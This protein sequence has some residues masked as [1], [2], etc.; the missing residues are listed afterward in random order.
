[1]VRNRKKTILMASPDPY[2]H[3][4]GHR[5]FQSHDTSIRNIASR[6]D[7]IP[8]LKN[9]KPDIIIFD[10]VLADTTI[11]QTIGEIKK[12]SPELFVVLISPDE[13][14]PEFPIDRI[15]PMPVEVIEVMKIAWHIF[16]EKDEISSEEKEQELCRLLESEIRSNIRL[17]DTHA[18]ILHQ[19]KLK[20]QLYS[21][22]TSRMQNPINI[23]ANFSTLMDQALKQSKASPALIKLS[24]EVH[25]AD[26][27]LAKLVEDLVEYTESE[28]KQPRLDVI[29]I[30]LSHLFES[31]LDEI[32]PRLDRKLQ[33]LKI[34]S[35]E[36]LPSL[37]IDPGALKQAL[38]LYILSLSNHI[39]E[40]EDIIIS[41]KHEEKQVSI[42]IS[43]SRINDP[44]LFLSSLEV[45]VARYL[46]EED[47]GMLKID[48]PPKAEFVLPASKPGD[49]T[50]GTFD[51][52]PE[53]LADLARTL[54]HTEKHL[55]NL[56]QKLARLYEQESLRTRK[57]RDALENMEQTYLQT[58]AAMAQIIDKK[59]SYA[60]P[61]TDRVSFFATIIAKKIAPSLINTR[62][63][64]YGLVLHDI[65]K[66]GIAEEILSKAEKLTPQEWEQIK[67]HPDIGTKILAPIEF[68]NSSLAAV[69][70]HH[71]RWDGKGYPDGLKGEEIP[72]LARIIALA[73]AFDAMISD[74][75]Y[76]K[77]LSLK[78]AKEDIIRQAGKQFDPKIV[79]AFLESWDDVEN[80]F[81]Q[82]STSTENGRPE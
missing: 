1:M 53:F 20:N 16:R 75:P 9:E 80:Y 8:A 4:L 17:R 66:I 38:S 67:S 35:P 14:E 46:I 56:S 33:R 6:K 15:L 25:E 81:S 21:L 79:K 34:E 59:D 27:T 77:G 64:K 51:E 63:F 11:F 44:D 13:A 31:L 78:E 55:L 3:T 41:V 29:E 60:G 40:R 73:D 48:D 70:W 19:E 43:S 36:N 65:G 52:Q 12:S 54:S 28:E 58:I 39:P 82:K 32:A 7:L 18:S 45:A 37:R 30:S 22:I 47:G 74:R 2:V 23:V 49:R 72:L 69:R 42:E 10:S 71:E 5:I 50:L 61:H 26:Q 57:L 76:R 62:E 24:E 68:L